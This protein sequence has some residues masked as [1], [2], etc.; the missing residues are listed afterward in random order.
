MNLVQLWTGETNQVKLS[1]IKGTTKQRKDDS[2]A[3]V[4]DIAEQANL[5]LPYIPDSRPPPKEH[6]HARTK[7]IDH[8]IM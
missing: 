5:R 6:N 8:N 2:V 4:L 1:H 7:V 3:M